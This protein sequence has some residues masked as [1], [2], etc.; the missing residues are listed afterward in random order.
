MQLNFKFTEEIITDNEEIFIG[1]L[2]GVIESV[3]EL[4]AI[5]ITRLKDSYTF[6]IAPSI[7][8]YNNI[9]LQEVLKFNNI[10]GIRLNIS[11]SIKTSGSINFEISL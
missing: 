7:P 9:I 5:Q 4:C 11:K 8:K 1:C 10:F 6:R 3:D 2:L